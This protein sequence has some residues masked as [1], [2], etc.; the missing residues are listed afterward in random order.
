MT[1]FLLALYPVVIIWNLQIRLQLKAVITFL[2]GL[3]V[4]TGVCSIVKTQQF[5]RLR[6]VTKNID[7]T[8]KSQHLPALRQ[9]AHEHSRHDCTTHDSRHDGDVDRADR[10]ERSSVVASPPPI[11]TNLEPD[12]ALQPFDSRQQQ[13]R[14]WRSRRPRLWLGPEV[15]T[16][17]FVPQAGKPE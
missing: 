15:D 4:I 14:L 9:Q 13:V 3:G 16:E 7:P 1:D 17:G 8:C 11:Y 10:I 2:M 6:D 12:E 5:G